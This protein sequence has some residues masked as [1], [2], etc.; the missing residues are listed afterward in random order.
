MCAHRVPLGIV[1][2]KEVAE[3]AVGRKAVALGIAMQQGR[4]DWAHLGRGTANCTAMVVLCAV[5]ILYG[6]TPTFWGCA[7]AAVLVP[8]M[9]I[10]VSAAWWVS[11]VESVPP[12]LAGEGEA[13]GSCPH[14]T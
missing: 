4:F 14:P 6:L 1:E 9:A 8:P 10:A 7:F 2:V 5:T 12:L 13:A 3:R 11:V